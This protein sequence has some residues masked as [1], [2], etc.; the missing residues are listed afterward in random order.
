MMTTLTVHGQPLEM[1]I[2]MGVSVSIVSKT[3]WKSAWKKGEEPL[4]NTK[5][6]LK[7]YTC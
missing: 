5:K 6:T 4:K 2:D 3:T 7:T 1:E